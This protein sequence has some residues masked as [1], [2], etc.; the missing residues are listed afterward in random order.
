V[1]SVL[2]IN[3]MIRIVP[4]PV[5]ADFARMQQPCHSVMWREFATTVP[6]YARTICSSGQI[7][8]ARYCLFL[9]LFAQ[10]IC[11]DCYEASYKGLPSK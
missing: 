3:G 1:I 11:C 2:V 4:W 7:A 9:K 8:D 5:I 6:W 10:V